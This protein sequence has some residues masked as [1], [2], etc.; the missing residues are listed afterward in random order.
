MKS[1]MCVNSPRKKPSRCL[2]EV[3]LENVKFWSWIMYTY[4]V[5]YDYNF[6]Q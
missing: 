6:S 3:R 5:N 4:S 2:D 1:R